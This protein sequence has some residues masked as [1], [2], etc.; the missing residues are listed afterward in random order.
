MPCGSYIQK[1]DT[2]TVLWLT[3]VTQNREHESGPCP[4]FLTLQK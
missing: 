2:Q 3:D 4:F 1:N